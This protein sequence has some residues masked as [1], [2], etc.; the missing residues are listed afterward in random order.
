MTDIL[1]ALWDVI[2]HPLRYPVLP[3]QR[4]YWVYLASALILAGAIYLFGHARHG[5]YGGRGLVRF[6]FPKHIYAHRSA[7]VD[8]KFFLLNRILFPVFFAPLIVGTVAVSDSTVALLERVTGSPGP[9]WA[10]GLPSH[11]LLTLAFVVTLDAALFIAHYLQHKV[12]L[13]WE[14]HKVH[15]SAEVLTPITVYRMHPMDDLF[16]GTLVALFVGVVW[17]VFSHLHAEGIGVLTVL[18]VNALLFVYYV[19]GYN[20]R[21]SHVWLSYPRVLSHVF[22]SPAQH[23]IHHSR[24]PRHFDK[25]LG[26]IFAFWDYLAGTLYVPRQYEQLDYGL[27]RDEHREF[28]TV[29]RLYALPVRKA[30]AW[31]LTR[32]NRLTRRRE[33][34]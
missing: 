23:Q 4:I 31:L 2:V 34:V 22:V 12:P 7:R 3:E 11:L 26:F 24:N 14:F 10:P 5:R 28:D 6:W 29:W 17:G 8:Y 16:S 27:Y 15:H 25:N 20:L 18:H 1:S 33:T 21:H 19:A 32:R 13:L 9:G 30:A